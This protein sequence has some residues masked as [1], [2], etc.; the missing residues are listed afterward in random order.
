MRV[1]DFVGDSS[2]RLRQPAARL[3]RQL[4]LQLMQVA[5]FQPATNFW[6]SIE[7]PVLSQ[8]LP[9]DG[10]GLDIGCGDGELTKLLGQML[11][12][13]WRLIG[14]DPD[15][16]ETAL[17]TALGVYQRVHTALADHI[18]EADDSCDF[19]FANSVLEHIPNL[20]DC[21]REIGRCLKPRGLF[22]AT[23]PGPAFRELL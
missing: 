17:A 11:S 14:I 16:A 22:A 6:R 20:S 18:P 13:R 3:K 9:S 10:L 15:P 19:A 7:L 21:L 12:A 23:V 5:P 4:L 8:V 1:L 2:A